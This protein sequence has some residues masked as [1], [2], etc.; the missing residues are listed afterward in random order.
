MGKMLNLFYL[1]EVVE[2]KKK[3]KKV[4]YIVDTLKI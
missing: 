4:C 2:V 1:T 3:S